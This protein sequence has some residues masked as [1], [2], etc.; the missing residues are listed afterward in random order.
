MPQGGGPAGG[1]RNEEAIL[2][3]VREHLREAYR[4]QAVNRL[5]FRFEFNRGGGR[6]DGP[7]SVARSYV[8][9]EVHYSYQEGSGAL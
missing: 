6:P 8:E 4:N 3:K 7:R 5:T 2:A 1:F 9:L